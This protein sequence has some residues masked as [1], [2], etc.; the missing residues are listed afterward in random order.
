MLLFAPGPI[1]RPKKLESI[2]A[3]GRGNG[4]AGLRLLG[5]SEARQ[6]MPSLSDRIVA[7]LEVEGEH[8]I[9]PWSAAACLS[10]PGRCTWRKVPAQ[11]GT[12]EGQFSTAAGDWR[13]LPEGSKPGAV[14]NTAGL[15]GDIVDQCLGPRCSVSR[16][17]RAR[18]SSWFSIKGGLSTCPSHRAASFRVK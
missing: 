9:D 10:Y 1:L 17:S 15:Y 12:F 7:A 8:V 4:I 3:Q 14:I 6:T 2:Q 13:H 5:G 11:R 18:A 16:S